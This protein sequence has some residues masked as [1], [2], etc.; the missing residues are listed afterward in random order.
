[1]APGSTSPVAHQELRT[2]GSSESRRLQVG[3]ELEMD[4]LM[5]IHGRNMFLYQEM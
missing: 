2:I 3:M 5:W 4:E 1:M